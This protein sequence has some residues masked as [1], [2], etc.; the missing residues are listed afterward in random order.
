MK[1]N[2]QNVQEYLLTSW[3]WLGPFTNTGIPSRAVRFFL[4][5]YRVSR[6][7]MRCMTRPHQLK[8]DRPDCV[9]VVGDF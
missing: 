1:V 5:R 6:Y 4:T 9:A 7:E 3:R 8:V 2:G